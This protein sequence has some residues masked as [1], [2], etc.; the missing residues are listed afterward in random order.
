MRL[1]HSCHGVG[2][3]EEEEEEDHQLVSQ[4]NPTGSTRVVDVGVAVLLLQEP[5]TGWEDGTVLE[6][7]LQYK[8]I[9]N[10]D[11][12]RRLL[13]LPRS[14]TGRGNPTAYDRM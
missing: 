14:T 8:K 13:L 10:G 1:E 11:L 5:V 3:L 2:S 9:G 7:P 12:P 4:V 6:K